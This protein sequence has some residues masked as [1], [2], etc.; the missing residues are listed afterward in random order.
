MSIQRFVPTF[1]LTEFEPGAFVVDVGC[2]GGRYLEE[3]AKRGHGCM[4]VEPD[5]TVLMELRARTLNAV[6]GIAENLPLAAASTDAVLCSV[7]LPYTDERRAVAEWGRVLRPGGEVR[8][9]FHGAGYSVWQIVEGVSFKMRV[10]GVRTLINTLY[11]RLTGRRLPGWV[12]DTLYQSA[13]RLRMYYDSAGLSVVEEVRGPV[14]MG[15]QVFFAHRLRR[16][17][18]VELYSSVNDTCG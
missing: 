9:T 14:F 6:Q 8:A 5:P 11:Y 15:M 18:D 17:G 3:L 13:D 2:G 4:G 16:L 12:G 10:Y 1:A 7:A